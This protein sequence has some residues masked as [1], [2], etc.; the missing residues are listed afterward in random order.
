MPQEGIA[1]P[2]ALAGPLD[3]P[4]NVSHIEEGR[5]LASWL[6]MVHQPVKPGVRNRNP[7]QVMMITFPLRKER[8]YLASLGSI[9]QKGKFSV[10]AIEDLVKTL[11][12]V[13]FPTFGNPT[14]P[15]L[16]LVPIRP[17]RTIFSSA[18]S[19][20]LGGIVAEIL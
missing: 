7:G 16:R 5:N 14:M 20:F 15:H 12:K 9:V 6:V 4:S 3:Q 11:K 19:F 10:A 18:T 1:Q 2:L 17:M 8:P 13:D